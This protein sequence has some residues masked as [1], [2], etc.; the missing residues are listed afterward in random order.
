MNIRAL[1]TAWVSRMQGLGALYEDG[2]Y[3]NLQPGS[4]GFW[5]QKLQSV[6]I[7]AGYTDVEAPVLGQ[8]GPKTEGSVR[9]FQADAGLPVTGAVDEM[10]WAKLQLAPTS[11]PEETSAQERLV[12]QQTLEGNPPV[13]DMLA[14]PQNAG[15]VPPAASALT[16]AATP[17]PVSMQEM[18]VRSPSITDFF[19]RN[20]LPIL[21]GGGAL[22]VFFL[23]R[24]R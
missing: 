20:K 19:M 2:R 12:A 3:P 10:T 9:K 5:V 7:G 17:L 24:G 22:L 6:L 13:P 15:I 4:T 23:F 11:R 8:Y 18:M 21:L 16:L 1:Q 14:V